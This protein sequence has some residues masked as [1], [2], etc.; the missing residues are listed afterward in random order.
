MDTAGSSGAFDWRWMGLGT[1]L[2][3][4]AALL[5][6]VGMQVALG[7][8]L[9]GLSPGSRLMVLLGVVGSAFFVGGMLVGRMSAGVTLR[10]PALAGALSCV[11][12]FGAARILVWADL[13]GF[14]AVYD[15]RLSG[16]LL[17]VPMAV[18]LAYLGGWVG[19]KWQ[20]TI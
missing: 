18:G 1:L 16:L 4:A 8:R 20:G 19:E 15:L 12:V 11:L 13:G 7:E 17:L 5:F 6:L 9:T 3:A 14:R 2:M 10:E